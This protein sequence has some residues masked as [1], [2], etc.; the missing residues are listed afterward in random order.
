MKRRATQSGSAIVE[1][2]LVVP[3]YFMIIFALVQLGIVF[4]GYC[5]AQYAAQQ[6]VRYA[7]VHGS[8]SSNPCSGATI[9]AYVAP[10]LWAAQRNSSTVTATW[11]PNNGAGST[12]TVSITLTYQ[13]G[14]PFS[15]LH[16]LTV[17][18]TAQGTI[19]Y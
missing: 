14:L 4:A 16:T 11:N 6:G 18:T 12:V 9:S 10:Y 1:F 8:E 2:A 13:T 15:A 7:I 5:G 19:L 3:L 17:G